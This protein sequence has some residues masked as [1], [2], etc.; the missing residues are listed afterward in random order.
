MLPFEKHALDSTLIRELQRVT[1]G[2]GGTRHLPPGPLPNEL[3][4]VQSMSGKRS[5]VCRGL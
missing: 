3:E 1:R 2:G 5:L 4:R